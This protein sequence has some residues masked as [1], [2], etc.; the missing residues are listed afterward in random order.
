MPGLPRLPYETDLS[1]QNLTPTITLSSGAVL[2][3]DSGRA[4]N[5]GTALTCTVTA[6]NGTTQVYLVE[7]ITVPKPVKII[8]GSSADAWAELKV[9][10]EG[11]GAY[12]GTLL[13]EIIINGEVKAA[14]G[15]SGEIFVPGSCTVTIK[16]NGAEA[17]INANCTAIGEEHRIFKIE[18]GGNLC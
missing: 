6:E 2:F 17:V 3:P 1:V 12:A 4:Q 16:G 5:F 15:S 9:A 7:V 11:T 8:N 13:E 18:T 14:A 10:V